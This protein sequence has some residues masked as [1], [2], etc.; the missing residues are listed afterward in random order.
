M[1]VCNEYEPYQ[2]LKGMDLIV[3]WGLCSLFIISF[4]LSRPI[5]LF[6]HLSSSA[7]SSTLLTPQGPAS[8][9]GCPFDINW[10]KQLKEG[11]T[12]YSVLAVFLWYRLFKKHRHWV[13]NIEM[14][15]EC[16]IKSTW[17]LFLWKWPAMFARRA[18]TATSAERKSAREAE[19]RVIIA[20]E[21]IAKP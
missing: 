9:Q 8:K 14:Q 19:E 12:E 6:S 17:W 10:Y 5:Y 21:I 11:N 1:S 16:S 4:I 7:A 20:K 15:L 2:R 13:W 18:F 3:E